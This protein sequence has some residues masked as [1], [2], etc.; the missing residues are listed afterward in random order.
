MKTLLTIVTVTVKSGDEFPKI[1]ALGYDMADAKR[2]AVE[3]LK[4]SCA[5]GFTSPATLSSGYSVSYYAAEG[6]EVP[7]WKDED[8]IADENG[9]D[10]SYILEFEGK[11]YAFSPRAHEYRVGGEILSDDLRKFKTFA[12]AEVV[13]TEEIRE[14]TGLSRTKFSKKYNVPVRTLENWDAGAS[15]CPDYVKEL[16]AFKVVHDVLQEFS[17]R[18]RDNLN[19]TLKILVNNVDTEMEFEELEKAKYYF[20]DS[21]NSAEFN[22]EIEDAVDLDDL[23]SVLNRYTDVE[24]NGSCFTVKEL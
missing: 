1:T 3:A 11:R 7:N 18:E 19:D 12:D 15:K 13:T 4:E 17:E 22:K 16:L 2:E 23:A 9:W 5:S 8:D 21:A 14:C 24:G 20:T 10:Y 6:I